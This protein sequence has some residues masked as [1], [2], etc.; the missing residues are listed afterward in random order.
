MSS[1]NIRSLD[2]RFFFPAAINR[3]NILRSIRERLVANDCQKRLFGADWIVTVGTSLGAV[4]LAR[5]VSHAAGIGFSAKFMAVLIVASMSAIGIIPV[6]SI[7]AFDFQLLV[8][9]I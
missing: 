6:A 1:I 2:L 8:S 9:R 3:H 7:Y 5:A 4:F